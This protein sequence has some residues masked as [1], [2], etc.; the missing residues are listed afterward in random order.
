MNGYAAVPHGAE[1]FAHALDGEGARLAVVRDQTRDVGQVTSLLAKVL[2]HSSTIMFER[3]SLR[4]SSSGYA[5]ARTM[6]GGTLISPLL[7]GT[8]F[9]CHTHTLFSPWFPRVIVPL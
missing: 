8:R 6:V 9:Q 3:I 7:F 2:V 5:T 4:H 1:R